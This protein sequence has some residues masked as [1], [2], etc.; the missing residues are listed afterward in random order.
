MNRRDAIKTL[1]WASLY[2][3]SPFKLIA[4]TRKRTIVDWLEEL[5]SDGLR[6]TGVYGSFKAIE[7]FRDHY[8]LKEALPPRWWHVSDH[9]GVRTQFVADQFDW[10]YSAP[11][12]VLNP[13][14]M[15][16]C[17][18]GRSF[19][20]NPEWVN[21]PIAVVIATEGSTLHAQYYDRKTFELV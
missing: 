17:G 8:K 11:G 21:A 18:V 10:R 6:V 2:V 1:G 5:R 15:E 7:F 16:A 14:I 4:A 3:C 13:M 20:V 12:E 19:R 9:S